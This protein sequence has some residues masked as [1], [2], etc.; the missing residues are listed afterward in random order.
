[1]T[2]HFKHI[3]REWAPW[4]SG[5]E[6]YYLQMSSTEPELCSLAGRFSGSS[7]SISQVGPVGRDWALLLEA[8][9]ALSW[10]SCP[11]TLPPAKAS[12]SSS[13]DPGQGW[14][15]E[16]WAS[17]LPSAEDGEVVTCL[18][19]TLIDTCGWKVWCP[20]WRQKTQRGIMRL[21]P[22]GDTVF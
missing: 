12:S 4:G 3:S 11:G 22:L 18:V 13:A 14:N 19:A 1:M 8:L 2:H 21:C 9:R 5:R 16:Q 15:S 10:V 17:A 20:A 6:T 7:L